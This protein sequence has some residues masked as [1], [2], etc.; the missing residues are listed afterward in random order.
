MSVWYEY[1]TERDQDS[2][3]ERINEGREDG[4]G[5]ISGDELTKTLCD[6]SVR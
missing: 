2:D 1:T 6:I 3:D 4:I 5:S